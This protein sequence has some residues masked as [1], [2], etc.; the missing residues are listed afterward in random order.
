MRA[1]PWP[2]GWKP[3]PGWHLGRAWGPQGLAHDSQEA[4]GGGAVAMPTFQA[5]ARVLVFVPILPI[6][7]G[8][9]Q[10]LNAQLDP[11]RTF[12]PWAQLMRPVSSPCH[13]PNLRTAQ[14]PVAVPWAA[15][16]P[17]G[18]LS[19]RPLPYLINKTLALCPL[20]L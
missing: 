4:L 18:R 13:L 9:N 5:M 15:L 16:P 19:F 6:W 12:P 10:R 7:W 14:V 11:A 1:G 20:C 2:R 3:S 17:P 8:L